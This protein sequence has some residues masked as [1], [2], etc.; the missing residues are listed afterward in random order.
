M[1]LSAVLP[2]GVY[3]PRFRAP[4]KWAYVALGVAL[5][6][7]LIWFAGPLIAFAGHA[8][9]AKVLWRLVAIAVVIL[10]V[11]G[12][13]LLKRL[14]T[15]RANAAMV[16]A[17][18]AAPEAREAPPAPDL[19]AADVK[20]M[21]ERAARALE[22]MRGARVGAQR[23]LVYE[24]P[25]Y[26]IIG[27]PGAGKTTALRNCGLHFP[28]AQETGAAPVR[29][30]GG[31][32][33]ADWWFTDRAVLIDTAGRY[34]TQDSD[35][36]VDSKAWLGFLDILKRHRPRQPLTGVIVALPAPDLLAADESELLAHAR[37]VR[38]R[39]NEIGQ[40]F[41]VRLPVY[42]LL[43]KM[44][45]LAGFTE[46]FDDLDATGRE[47]VWGHTFGLRTEAGAPA[48]GLSGAGEAVDALVRR[49]DARL[50]SRVQAERDME[51][52]GLIF[53]F[54]Q[55]VAALR[56]PLLP[57]LETLARETRFEPP[58]L[59]RGVYFTSGTQFGRPI[60]RLLASLSAKFGV[61]ATAVGGAAGKGRAYFLQDLLNKVIFPEAALAGRDPLT[62]T[63]RRNLR[64][65]LIVGGAALTLLL[66]LGWLGGYL[67]NERLIHLLAERSARL[68]QDVRTLPGGDVSDSDLSGVLPVLDEARALPFNA[69]A[70]KAVRSPGF[71]FGVGRTG[72]LRPQ[73]EGA[74][75]NL[76]NRL[77]LPRLILG[78][79][80]RLRALV[81][82]SPGEGAAE[83]A[84]GAPGAAAADNRSQIYSLLRIYLMLGRAE[85]APLEKQQI[86]AWFAESWAESLPGEEDDS[87]RADLQAHLASLL[88]GPLSP[89]TLDND[90]ITAA[91]AQVSSLSPGERAY[92]RLLADPT[93]TGLPAY[94]LLE[95]PGVGSSGLFQLRSGKP[96][97]TGVPGMF[98]RS[99]FY[100]PVLAAIGK[101]AATTADDGWVLGRPAEGA[102]LSEA[103]RVKDGILVAYLQDFTRRWDGFIADIGV[104]GRYPPDE[105]IRR[106]LQPPSPV[107]LLIQSLANETNLT[108]PGAPG[109]AGL[110]GAALR[111]SSLFSRRI[112]SGMNRANQIAQVNAGQPPS[113]P[114]PLDEVVEHY[115]WLRELTPASGGPSPIDDALSALKDVAD[116]AGAAKAASSMGDPVLQHEK[117]GSA[118]AA[119]SK[120][121]EITHTLPPAAA[122]LFTGF[123]TSSTQSLNQGARASIEQQYA[124]QILPQCR[125]ILAQG[126]PFSASIHQVSIDD[127]SRLLRPGGLLDQFQ[128]ANL[129][130]QIDTS[131]RDWGLTSSGRALGLELAGVRELQK[132][133]RIRQ[134][135]FKPGDV[136]PNV[137]FLLEPVGPGSGAATVTL[138]VDGV[139]AAF[140]PERKPV[141][142]HWPGPSPGVSLSFQTK[143]GSAPTV[144]SWT[145]DFAF[146]QML[147][148]A[149]VSAVGAT[150]ATFQVGAG[151][152]TATLRL[153]VE[154][155]TADPF[156]LPELR[157]FACP[158]KL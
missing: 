75:R 15:R 100:G 132:A 157:T 65:A 152:Q 60:D 109:K 46:F 30:I 67:G 25:W 8:P 128:T 27:P 102:P 18:A 79:E 73:V 14:R 39:I 147:R 136:R 149:Q 55:Q 12:W 158:A 13:I 3:V 99:A 71:S 85:G 10:A 24:L 133:D 68:E 124:S 17:L 40:R 94:T 96:L 103:G 69:D 101:A 20:A 105:R 16:S 142:L 45:L 11:G 93:L 88:A 156:L 134:A 82:A 47:Q 139:P 7:V 58:P 80:E 1:N 62:E 34:T 35:E 98:R 66:C 37:A 42:V 31:T 19:S 118:M 129:T 54:P 32:R 51:R 87:L 56:T 90:L 33:T 76:L 2:A 127:F 81:K 123:V 104:S 50:L 28:A 153:R 141:E 4:P 120:L 74:Y 48:E 89:P 84:S 92:S 107:K 22:L 29:G 116:S 77:M 148:E 140:G 106:A 117:T 115:R 63:R 36:A 43:T 112:Y 135:F 6:A 5:V 143:P 9:L 21:E 26:V 119:T 113:P 138:T 121:Q 114:G 130:G 57:L 59:V 131:G 155:A 61:S 86:Q 83:E 38:A 41:G 52:R 95:A 108:P 146:L 137:R 111:T 150:S 49:L 53:G 91:R 23:E 78:V 154:N 145:G 72:A 144:K 126:F 122:G 97:T 151:A 64:L 70:P 110:A 125:A 44:D